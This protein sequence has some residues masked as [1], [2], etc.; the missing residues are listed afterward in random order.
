MRATSGPFTLDHDR[1]QLTRDGRTLPIG[2]RGFVLF[3]ALVEAKGEA[4][5]KDK[6][7]EC[8]WPG[9]IVE[10][11]NLSVQISALRRALGDDG[12]SFIITVPRVGYRLVAR[13]APVLLRGPPLIAVLPVTNHDSGA[14]S[15]SFA[16]GMVDDLIVALSRF[17]T[18]GVLS[19]S[20]SFALRDRGSDALAA[21]RELGIRYAL[22]G[23]V[24]REANRLRVTAKLLD[25]ET[26]TPLWAEKYDGD[27]TEVFTFQDRITEAVV[28]LVEPKIRVAEIERVRRKPPES[29]DAYE[30]YLKALP[31]IYAPSPQGHEQALALLEKS[32]ELDPGFGLAAAY[33]AWVYEKRISSRL[34]SLGNSDRDNCIALAYAALKANSDDP[35]LRA[36]C[37]FVLYRVE[38]N[39]AMLEGL[40]EA[41]R[42]NPNSVVILNLCGI[43]YQMSGD[44]DEALRFRTRAYE[45]GPSA[46]DAY[47]SL[48][49]MGAAEMMRGN[50][51]TAVQW[52]LRSLATFNEWPFTYMTLATCYE[53]LG[54]REDAKA[55]V[56]RLRE[57]NPTLT[58]SALE[59]GVDRCDDA[60]GVAVIPSLRA[61]GLPER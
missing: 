53:R 25:A 9:L 1:R 57:L 45:L 6:L 11:S 59:E 28:G 3:A 4:V 49:G 15:T 17:R 30:Y 35:L 16:D 61:A 51:E 36:I 48:H 40:R 21:A 33:A 18:F 8:A 14:E 7:M 58:L 13:A 34:P 12:D 50:L 10:E 23:S 24:T 39:V 5:S 47:V 56:Q 31:L 20:A 54:R 60:Y 46:P 29:L 2:Q 44:A 43:G 27:V 42:A 38:R 26:G 32:V 55:M 37:S 22:E 41:V 52:C 19:R